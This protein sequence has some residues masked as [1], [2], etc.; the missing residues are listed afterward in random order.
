M[1]VLEFRAS[2]LAW[3]LAEF[4]ERLVLDVLVASGGALVPSVWVAREVALVTDVV[5]VP[6]VWVAPAL[7]VLSAWV[8]LAAVA[9]GLPVFDANLALRASRVSGW[10]CRG[11][12]HPSL[13]SRA[14]PA[15]R[16]ARAAGR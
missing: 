15:S 14:L 16:D 12:A 5:A 1:S 6:R 9:L 4:G 3:L 10:P 7:L 2:L 8:D 13:R 11:D